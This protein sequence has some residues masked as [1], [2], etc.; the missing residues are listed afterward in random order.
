MATASGNSDTTAIST[1][2]ASSYE[3]MKEFYEQVSTDYNGRNL[4]FLCKLC[5]PG[6]KKQVRTSVSSS[7]NLKRHIE[8]MHPTSLGKYLRVNNDHKKSFTKAAP[9]MTVALQKAKHTIELKEQQIQHLQEKVALLT[10]ERVFLRGLLEDV[11]K[12]RTV[13]VTPAS[14]VPIV[15]SEDDSQVGYGISSTSS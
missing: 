11:L 4:T 3:Y 7:T 15:K 13:S 14:V 10:E 5:P 9:S 2:E 12:G 6:L 8:L 1:A